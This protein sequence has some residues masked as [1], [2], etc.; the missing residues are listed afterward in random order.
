MQ[1][2][3][4]P[5][6]ATTRSADDPVEVVILDVAHGNCTILRDGR[7]CAVI[8]ARSDRV[9]LA[10]L[11]RMHIQ[12]IEHVVLSHSDEDHIQGALRLLP[13]PDFEIGKVWANSDSVQDSNLWDELLALICALDDAGKLEA[14]IGIS[15]ADRDRLSFGSIGISVLH[16]SPY[17]IGH[18]PG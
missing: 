6:D 17:E 4:F 9:L 18:G 5:A 7:S 11:K 14:R 13:H 1:T 15:T 3:D 8:D 12:R 2:T 10:E 16:P